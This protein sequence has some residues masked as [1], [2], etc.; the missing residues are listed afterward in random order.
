MNKKYIDIIL[1]IFFI[2]LAILLYG[3]A[4]TINQ[5]V[6]KAS[7]NST[8]TYVNTL[9]IILAIAGII[10]LIKN[11]IS[12]PKVIQFTKNPKKFILLIIFLVLYVKVMEYFG[13]I[14]STFLFLIITIIV[15]GYTKKTNVIIISI[16]ITS[17]IY[18]LFQVGFEILLPEATIF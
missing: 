11:I 6:S 5:A 16:A 10:E 15:M 13:F 3:S 8:S 9:A 7:T 2:V 17:V 4:D 12:S 18:I 14:I 1:S